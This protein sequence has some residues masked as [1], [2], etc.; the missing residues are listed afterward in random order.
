MRFVAA[1][2]S[3]R[4]APLAVLEAAAVRKADARSLLRYLVGHGGFSGAAVL[5]TCNRTEFYVTC[6]D[7][8][9]SDIPARLA[10]HLDPAGVHGVARHLTMRADEEALRHLFRVA[11]GLES[12]VVGEAQ[13]L[14]QLRDAHEMARSAGTLDA[15]LDFVMRRATS[16]GKTVRARTEIG[17]GIGSLSEVAVDCAR[18]VAGDLRGRG[19][20]LVGSGKMSVLAARRLH[21]IGA[22]I[23]ATS[24]GESKERL[25]RSVE[26]RVVPLGRVID[27][28]DSIDVVI[29]STASDEPVLAAE[30]VTRA[31]Q[32]RSGWNVRV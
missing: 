2:V 30:V 27:V 9:A 31:Q 24:R 15:R 3:H 29:C 14:G 1:G 28:A 21:E 16:V 23:L 18:E 26:S 13:V 11:A 17:R 25:A 32:P 4:T 20:L 7:D 6:P 10:P 12:M 5:S 19:V 8:D 22:R